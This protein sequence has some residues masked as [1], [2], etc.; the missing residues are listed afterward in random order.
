MSRGFASIGL[1]NPKNDLNVCGAMRAAAC[2]GAAMVA[3]IWT[4]V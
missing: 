2:Y 4:S 3:K 1:Y